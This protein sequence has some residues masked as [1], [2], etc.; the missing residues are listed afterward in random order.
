MDKKKYSIGII[1]P[2]GGH[3]G[4]DYYDYGLAM[5]LGAD[6]VEVLFYTCDETTERTYKKVITILHFKRMWNRNFLVKVFKYLNGHY[7]AILDLKKRDIRIIHLHFFT[8]RSIDL[9]ILWFAW[10]NKIKRVVTIHDVNSFDKK[11]NVFFEKKCFKYIDGIIVHNKSSLNILDDKFKLSI[12]KVIIP[13]G[14]YLP[15][16]NPISNFKPKNTEKFSLLFFGQIK[17]V[18]GLDILLQALSVLKKKNVMLSWLLQ[19]KLGK[20]I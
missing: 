17:K 11:A 1:E 15:F 5:G 20:T 13:H 3:G 9:L 14:N 19:E 4:M 2:V 8:F 7:S 6:N 18:K 12:P 16:I 10:L